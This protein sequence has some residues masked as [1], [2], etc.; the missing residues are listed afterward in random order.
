[1]GFFRRLFRKEKNSV[2]LVKVDQS[3]SGEDLQTMISKIGNQSASEL[4]ESFEGLSPEAGGSSQDLLSRLQGLDREDLPDD[5][6]VGTGEEVPEELPVEEKPAEPFSWKKLPS[7][8]GGLFANAGRKIWGGLKKLGPGIKNYFVKAHRSAVDDYNHFED[9]YK[10]MSRWGRFKWAA[11]NPLAWIR[12][13]KADSKIDT[14]QRDMEKSRLDRI[15]RRV[16]SVFGKSEDTSE[17]LESLLGMKEEK[18]ASKKILSGEEGPGSE[19]LLPEGD[20]SEE[21]GPEGT[22][23]EGTGLE[24]LLKDPGLDPSLSTAGQTAKGIAGGLSTPLLIASSALPVLTGIKEHRSF[25]V[26]AGA[27]ALADTI[28]S[29]IQ[30]KEMVKQGDAYEAGSKAFDTA[31]AASFIGNAVANYRKIGLGST[32]AAGSH[33][34]GKV[35]PGIGIATGAMA[36]GSGITRIVGAKKQKKNIADIIEKLEQNKKTGSEKLRAKYMKTLH[37]IRDF[38][39][40]EKNKGI[41][42]TTSGALR[43][44]GNAML[45]SGI[46]AP[47]GVGLAKV[48]PVVGLIGGFAMKKQTS[49]AKKKAVDEEMGLEEKVSA[50][51]KWMPGLNRE[52]AKYVVFKSMGITSGTRSEAF[53]RMTMK[54]TKRLKEAADK[55]DLVAESI[56]RGMNLA[57][58]DQGY[59]EQ[60]IARKLGMGDE[61]WQQQVAEAIKKKE[62]DP[63]YNPFRE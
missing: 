1:M 58:T 9:D 51:R 63:S 8:V 17:S 23:P 2:P 31:Y 21:V 61:P 5:Y 6:D 20:S 42:N 26:M 19:E 27:S 25:E 34:A 39:D 60:A 32:S 46:G 33:I 59:N 45:L 28:N 40:I 15:A 53:L 55:G 43:T 37:Q 30:T 57:R 4:E 52:K 16:A 49:D 22:G 56:V 7:R 41:I 44:L 47:I 11:A 24:S 13:G 14:L 54:R 62:Y 29:G 35:L 50:L 12:G 38:T 48:A 10:K 18:P 3:K 36:M